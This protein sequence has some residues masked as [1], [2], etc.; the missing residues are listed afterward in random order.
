MT[1]DY[2]RRPIDPNAVADYAFIFCAEDGT[3][4][5]AKNG[6]WLAGETISSYTLTVVSGTVT[7][8]SDNKD[9]VTIDGIAYGANTVVNV[10]FSGAVV[11]DNDPPTVRCRVTTNS[12]RVDDL[13]KKLRV[14]ET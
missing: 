1:I 14:R 9:A 2:W 5:T 7:I 10:R 4:S 3:N 6:G 8:D 12:G 13:T 11:G